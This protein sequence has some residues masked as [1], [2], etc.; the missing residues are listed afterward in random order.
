MKIKIHN[1]L[2]SA[3]LFI[4]F[5]P[6]YAT[7]MHTHTQMYTHTHTHTHVHTHVHMH[8]HTEESLIVIHKE[9]N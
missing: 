8:T 7:H 1:R 3:Q 2:N 9:K 4:L 6:K 5:N